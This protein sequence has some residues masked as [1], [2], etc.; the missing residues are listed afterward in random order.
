[1]SCPHTRRKPSPE[2]HSLLKHFAEVEHHLA[3]AVLIHQRR[4][5]MRK[6]GK[7]LRELLSEAQHHGTPLATRLTDL[8]KV[9]HHDQIR[10][11][12]E[13]H[14]AREAKGIM[15]KISYYE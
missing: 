11:G 5:L 10:L 14:L 8:E 13:P 7:L 3:V 1:M 12:V 4:K 6:A 9:L 2:F 15:T